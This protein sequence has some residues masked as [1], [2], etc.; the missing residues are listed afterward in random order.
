MIYRQLPRDTRVR[1]C[2][3]PLRGFAAKVI[4]HP[5]IYEDVT[6]ELVVGGR[7]SWGSYKVGDLLVATRRELEECAS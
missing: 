7:G 5:G 3:E 6:V 1:F 4:D 2:E